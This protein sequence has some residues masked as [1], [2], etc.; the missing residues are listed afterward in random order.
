[1]GF[2]SLPRFAAAC[3]AEVGRSELRGAGRAWKLLAV[4]VLFPIRGS[5]S[6]LPDSQIG[7]RG[8]R[9]T[10][11]GPEQAKSTAAELHNHGQRVTTPTESVA[12]GALLL[13]RVRPPAGVPR[14]KET[15]LRERNVA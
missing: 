12:P 4:D 7:I 1:M 5:T 3:A 9:Q 13:A 6:S 2:G 14:A 10:F 15:S 8:L 11:Y